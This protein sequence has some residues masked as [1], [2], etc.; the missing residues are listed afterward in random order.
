MLSSQP[1]TTSQATVGAQGPAHTLGVLR[2]LLD[3]S[4][5]NGASNDG[6][7]QD[8]GYGLLGRSTKEQGTQPAGNSAE[9][10]QPMPPHGSLGKVPG[11]G[12]LLPTAVGPLVPCAM[13]AGQGEFGICG[14]GQVQ[15]TGTAGGVSEITGEFVSGL[16]GGALGM[17]LIRGSTGHGDAGVRQAEAMEAWHAW[18]AVRTPSGQ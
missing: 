13:R 18:S 6:T 14:R 16:G 7:R 2:L 12:P 4:D 1:A 15:V 10:G 8:G 17:C 9:E 11:R 5:D 3:E